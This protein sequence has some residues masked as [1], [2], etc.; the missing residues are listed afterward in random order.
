M[1]QN[2]S[3]TDCHP[4]YILYITKEMEYSDERKFSGI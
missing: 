4:I 3:L 1:K 2:Q